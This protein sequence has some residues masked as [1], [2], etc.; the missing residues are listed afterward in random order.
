NSKELHY[1]SPKDE[2]SIP[3]IS[4]GPPSQNHMTESN[5]TNDSSRIDLVDVNPEEKRKHI[6]RLVLMRFSSLYLSDSSK[7]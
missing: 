7:R 6:I 2:S 3:E 5:S 1:M 4:A